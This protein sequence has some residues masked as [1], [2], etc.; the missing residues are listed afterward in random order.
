MLFGDEADSE[1]R[2]KFKVVK[3][4]GTRLTDNEIKA[5]VVQAIE[6]FLKSENWDFGET[7]YY[8]ELATYVP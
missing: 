1:V 3:N 4:P 6:E 2:A 8:T 7:F 5:K